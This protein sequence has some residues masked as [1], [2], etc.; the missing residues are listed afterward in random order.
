MVAPRG[1]GLECGSSTWPCCWAGAASAR[2]FTLPPPRS[3]PTSQL[4]LLLLPSSSRRPGPSLRRQ[5]SCPRG[6]SAPAGPTTKRDSESRR[7]PLLLLLPTAE[8]E[9][10]LPRS[11]TLS[12]ERAPQQ[13]PRLSSSRA[14]SPRGPPSRGGPPRATGTASRGRGRCPSRSAGATWRKGGRRSSCRCARSSTTTSC[15][16][17]PL[18]LLPPRKT[19]SAVVAAIEKRGTWP[20]TTSWSRSRSSL[21]TC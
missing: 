7:L 1:R 4:L 11:R 18:P 8:E 6:R 15:S 9:A 10:R 13:T 19:R 14:A 21:G 3:P 5:S 20:S 16:L 17:L 2:S 12:R